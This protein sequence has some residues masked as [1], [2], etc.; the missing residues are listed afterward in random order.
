MQNNQLKMSARYAI[1]T[2][3]SLAKHA[4]SHIITLVL[5]RYATYVAYNKSFAGVH[6][7][8]K[9]VNKANKKLIRETPQKKSTKRQQENCRVFYVPQ[10]IPKAVGAQWTYA[11]AYPEEIED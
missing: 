9:H 10:A 3:K 1:V 4:K 11:I 8:Q 7:L 5:C 6:Q 2:T